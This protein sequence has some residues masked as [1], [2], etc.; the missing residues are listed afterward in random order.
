MDYVH[1]TTNNIILLNALSPFPKKS[2]LGL[3]YEM[4]IKL[5]YSSYDQNFWLNGQACLVFESQWF[6]E[7]L[8]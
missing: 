4:E 2:Y 5:H 6:L 3:P 1:L 8:N 7:I